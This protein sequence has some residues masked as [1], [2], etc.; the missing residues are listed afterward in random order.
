M[1]ET[2]FLGV[3]VGNRRTSRQHLAQFSPVRN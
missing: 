1:T 2:P 3:F